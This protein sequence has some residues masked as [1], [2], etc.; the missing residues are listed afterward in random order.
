MFEDDAAHA[1]MML[2][3][4]SERVD[5]FDEEFELLLDE[6]LLLEFDEEFELL[7]STTYALWYN[8]TSADNQFN[9]RCFYYDEA[10][11]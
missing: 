3:I 2:R 9:I 7:P 11:V 8:Y 1:A 4:R 10:A 5:D 6:E